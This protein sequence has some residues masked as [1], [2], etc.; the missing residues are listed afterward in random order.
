[1]GTNLRLNI[2]EYTNRILGV[3]KEKFGLKNKSEA[4]N[5]FADMFGDEFIEKEANDQ[6]IKKLIEIEKAHFR[7]YKNKKMGEKEFNELFELN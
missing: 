6:Y 7:K 1:M 5:R 3:I 2:S 4:L